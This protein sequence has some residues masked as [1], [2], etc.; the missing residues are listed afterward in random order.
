MNFFNKIAWSVAFIFIMHSGISVAITAEQKAQQEAATKK[1]AAPLTAAQQ[2]ANY[3][4]S[5]AGIN[6]KKEI[7]STVSITLPSLDTKKPALLGKSVTESMSL[8][9]AAISIVIAS[10]NATRVGKV[11]MSL[12]TAEQKLGTVLFNATKT[13]LT[14]ANEIIMKIN[15]SPLSAAAKNTML[16]SVNK[17]LDTLGGVLIC[18]TN[19]D[20]NL[21]EISNWIAT[22]KLQGL[23]CP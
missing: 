11:N 1:A 23:V 10:N 8:D 6:L 4:T 22:K 14:K 9:K 2:D 3:L 16:A 5:P 15:A 21:P 7:Q 19:K 17:A 20:L 13:F 12:S 18:T